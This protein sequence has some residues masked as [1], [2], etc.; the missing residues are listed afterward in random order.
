KY[1]GGFDNTFRFMNFE[2]N[3]L[4]TFQTG[5]YVYYGSN[6]G[7]HDQRFWNNQRDILNHWQKANDDAQF[8]KVI[9]GDNI[10]NGS[11]FPLDINVFKGDFLK[12]RSLTLTYNVPKSIIERA[13]L[14][15]TRLYVSGN[16]LAII[17]KYPGPDPEVSSN[18]NGAI[19]QGVD[20]NS[21]ANG[22][23]ITVGINIGF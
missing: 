19:N 10:S 5:F 11:S 16:N 9:F 8:P 6:A 17:T 7:L 13:R 23:T 21:I 18:G 14:S 1:I 15:S 22:R 20:R 3:G 4:M 12:L 2:L